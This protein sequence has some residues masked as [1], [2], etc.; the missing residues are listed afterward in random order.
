MTSS[1]LCDKVEMLDCRTYPASR[2]ILECSSVVQIE[3]KSE[4]ENIL[5]E[6]FGVSAS[7]IHFIFS[8]I[9]FRVYKR[10]GLMCLFIF[11]DVL[12]TQRFSRRYRRRDSRKE[13]N[14]SACGVLREGDHSPD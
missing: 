6:C 9:L 12:V 7:E 2:I 13:A 1:R 4:F 8:S 10:M 11:A 5:L 14:E 3:K